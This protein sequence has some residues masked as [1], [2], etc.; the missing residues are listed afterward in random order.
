MWFSLGNS[1]F[2]LMF[3]NYSGMRNMEEIRNR[4][5][6]NRLIKEYIKEVF[7]IIWKWV[8]EDVDLNV[9]FDEGLLRRVLVIWLNEFLLL[10][11]VDLGIVKRW[12]CFVDLNNEE[13]DFI[14]KYWWRLLSDVFLFECEGCLFGDCLVVLFVRSDIC[15]KEWWVLFFLINFLFLEVE[16]RYN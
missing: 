1:Y 11:W 6:C 3:V 4:V 8:E 16:L 15:R 2:W 10:I 7:E 12:S 13:V 9:L 14:L 5:L